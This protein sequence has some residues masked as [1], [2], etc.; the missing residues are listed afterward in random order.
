MNR[1]LQKVQPTT[2]VL[3][4]PKTPQMPGLRVTETLLPYALAG[5]PDARKV[6]PT[7]PVLLPPRTPQA[8]FLQKKKP[9]LTPMMTAVVVSQPCSCKMFFVFLTAI[10]IFIGRWHLIYIYIFKLGERIAASRLRLMNFI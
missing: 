6:Q 4:L 9:F 10:Y 7:T 5:L 8:A 1:S 2:L 3:S